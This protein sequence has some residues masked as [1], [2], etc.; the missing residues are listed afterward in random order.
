MKNESKSL[1]ELHKEAEIDGLPPIPLKKVKFNAPASYK[2]VLDDIRAEREKELAALKYKDHKQY[3]TI[4]EVGYG[5]EIVNVKKGDVREVPNWYYEQFKDKMVNV[6]ISSGAFTRD[7]KLPR[8]FVMDELLGAV[9]YKVNDGQPLT[10]WEQALHDKPDATMVK[11][12]LF[13]LVKN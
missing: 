12:P 8:G 5:D 2:F 7:G 4:C 3:R 1:K 13:M 10:E 6:P 9:R 11:L